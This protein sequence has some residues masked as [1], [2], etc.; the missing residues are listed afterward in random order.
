[1][2]RTDPAPDKPGM[3]SCAPEQQRLEISPPTMRHVALSLIFRIQA[4]G[5]G[6]SGPFIF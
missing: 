3:Q 4:P 1:M 6:F 2:M 5:D